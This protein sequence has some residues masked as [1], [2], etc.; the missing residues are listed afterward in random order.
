M[1][2]KQKF[3]YLMALEITKTLTARL[4]SYCERIAVAGSVR[5]EKPEIGDIEIVA[6]PRKKY[7]L[8]GSETGDH[9]LN[10]VDWTAF[11]KLIKNGSKYKQIELTEGINLDLFIVTPPAQ[12]G[13]QFMIRTGSADFSHRLVTSRR[14][15][16]LMPSNY[17]VKDGAIWSSN[18]V[19]ETPEEED[20][21][22]LIGVPFIEPVLRVK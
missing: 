16:G 7:D 18:H 15:G 13:V 6:I 22:N 9:A 17:K 4:M 21:F 11:G 5:R 20:V 1:A 2:T 8:F 19:I 14:F 10:S 3:S 12:W